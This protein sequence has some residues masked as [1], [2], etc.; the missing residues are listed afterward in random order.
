MSDTELIQALWKE[1]VLKERL[2]VIIDLIENSKVN[3]D[4]LRSIVRKELTNLWNNSEIP[5]LKLI[6]DKLTKLEGEQKIIPEKEI[7]NK[8]ELKA[9]NAWRR[10]K[11]PIIMDISQMKPKISEPIGKALDDLGSLCKKGKF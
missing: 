3:Q 11:E 7:K 5:T 8:P 2:G 4:N 6:L 1:I 9:I 10:I